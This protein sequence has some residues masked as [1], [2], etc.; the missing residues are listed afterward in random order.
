MAILTLVAA[1]AAALAAGPASAAAPAGPATPTA[2][3]SATATG[4]TPWSGKAAAS[5]AP[6]PSATPPAPGAP[7]ATASATTH[8]A[9]TASTAPAA[10]KAPAAAAARTA[11][12]P[13]LDAPPTQAHELFYSPG[14]EAPRLQASGLQAANVLKLILVLALAGAIFY[15][16]NWVMADTAVVETNRALWGGLALAAGLVGL[17]AAIVVP[18]L[19]IGLP[20]GC[21]VFGGV[22][23]IYAQ[24]RNGLVAPQ[25]KVLTKDH[26]RRIREGKVAA[27]TDINR[28]G[29]G[30][31]E[32][33]GRDIIFMAMDDLP[34]R[35]QAGTDAEREANFE[36]EHIVTTAIA[37]R[38]SS[39]G[40]V[41]RQGKGEVRFS[42]DGRI[43]AGGDVERPAADVF[44]AAVKHLARL[45]PSETRRPQEARIRAVA[46]GK[47]YE[48]RIKTSGTVR[49]EQI[50]IRLIDQAASQR[51][52]EDLGLADDHLAALKEALGRRPGLVLV[53][54][55]KD[56]GLTTT[57]HACLRQFDRYTN[58]II[59]FEPHV[60]IEMDNIQHI[61]I[62]QQ[63]EQAALG[64]MRSRLRMAPDVIAFDSLTLPGAAQA[65]AEAA[66][67]HTVLVGLRAVD[68]T[69]A[70]ARLATLLP[71]SD[72][73]VQRL[74][75]VVN[76]RLVRLL[77][78]DCKEAYRPNPEFVRK[79]NFGSQRVDVLYR[80]PSRAAVDEDKK[81]IVCP[82]CRNERFAGRTGLF[83]L[84]SLDDEAR[85]LLAGGAGPAD[86]RT[87]ARK[88]GMRNLQEE[89]LRLVAAGKTSIEE[90]LRVIKQES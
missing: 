46:G 9:P 66:R 35:P 63:D 74:Q 2:S 53:S 27:R 57:L 65:L 76:Q 28:G 71:G 80:P 85:A 77:C 5:A 19:Y 16:L 12:P 79:A 87:H 6:T 8:A 62:D 37:R 67:E 11:P 34:L 86:L 59:V 31:V 39:I 3:T 48:L 13:V 45:D 7:T 50:A 81:V 90:V 20:I 17:A 38:A 22:L 33:A 21:A 14:I 49:G 56:S 41:A 32:G 68:A 24:H 55:P 64:E 1:L 40:Y 83:E 44:A 26:W 58:N 88:L 54:S 52:L 18:M 10:P 78:A 42:I 69:Q 43:V 72:I 82:N 61:S 36:I 15:F 89:G 47:T 75:V 51:R 60:D 29:A 23:F 73:L 70:L 4:G 84:I 30:F 25:N